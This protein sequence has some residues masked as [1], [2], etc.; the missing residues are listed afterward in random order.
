MKVRCGRDRSSVRQQSFL[1]GPKLEAFCLWT[2]GI[3]GIVPLPKPFFYFSMI[4]LQL[5]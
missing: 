5:Q 2:G 4:L 3:E 1:E